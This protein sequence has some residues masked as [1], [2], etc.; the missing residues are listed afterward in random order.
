MNH[1][2]ESYMHNKS[3]VRGGSPSLGKW[4]AGLTAI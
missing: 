1:F 4:I 3:Q 2:V